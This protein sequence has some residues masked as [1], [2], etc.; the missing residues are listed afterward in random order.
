MKLKVNGGLKRSNVEN[1][2]PDS[3]VHGAENSRVV[4]HV[5]DGALVD[6][7]GIFILIADDMS[8]VAL[9][10]DCYVRGR[11]PL[12]TLPTRMSSDDDQIFAH[13]FIVNEAIH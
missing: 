3:G 5:I 12:A 4:G 11:S 2:Y 7:V 10:V 6:Q 1:R 9:N 13:T 8:T